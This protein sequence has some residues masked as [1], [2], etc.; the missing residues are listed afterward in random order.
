MIGKNFSPQN[1]LLICAASTAEIDAILIGLKQAGA[2]PGP[3]GALHFDSYSLLQTGVG[4]ASA[5]AALAFEIAA[6]QANGRKYGAVLNLGIAGSFS[7]NLERGMAVL[8]ES[9]IM[10]DEGTPL[11]GMPSW[12]SIEE[13]GFG[14]NIFVCKQSAWWQELAN[15]A[16]RKGPIATISTISG[17]RALFDAYIERTA[18]LAEAMEGAALALVCE[19]SGL[20]FAELRTISNICGNSNRQ[21]NPW[22]FKAALERISSIC[23]ALVVFA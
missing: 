8:S 17:N 21:E 14:K 12:R 19:H 16:D 15:L 23:A 1:K 11:A 22:D 9:C 2:A 20:E 3:F 10:A 6:A 7:E 4:K 5:A 13:A 18:A